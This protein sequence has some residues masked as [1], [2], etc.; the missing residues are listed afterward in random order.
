VT[1]AHTFVI[2][3]DVPAVYAMTALARGAGSVA[4]VTMPTGEAYT[5]VSSE[6]HAIQARVARIKAEIAALPNAPEIEWVRPMTVR[7]QR[8]FG[9]GDIT[10][11][12]EDIERAV[13]EE[14]WKEVRFT[15][16]GSARLIEEG[17]ID[18][19]PALVRKVRGE[20]E[21]ERLRA[22]FRTSLDDSWAYLYRRVPELSHNP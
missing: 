5:I 9:W 12:R 16:P 10:A 15:L 21:S 6:A 8:L 22:D 3:G 7:L 17:R 14:D 13:S 2:K 18:E 20:A 4:Q 11:T 1:K 19:L